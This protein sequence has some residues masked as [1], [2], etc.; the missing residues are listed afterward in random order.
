MNA[1]ASHVIARHAPD[2]C[3]DEPDLDVWKFDP[4][5]DIP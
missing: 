4:E 2:E 3:D 1:I 5:V